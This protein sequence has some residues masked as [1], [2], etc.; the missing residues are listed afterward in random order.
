MSQR[1]VGQF[2]DDLAQEYHDKLAGM[3]AYHAVTARMI[4]AGVSNRVLSIGGLWNRATPEEFDST[5]LVGDLSVAMLR[6]LPDGTAGVLSDARG[7]PFASGAFDHLVFPLVLHHIT[8]NRAHT[9]RDNV[10]RALAEAR[11]LLDGGGT[12][13]ISEFCV[14]AMVY[15]AEL[16]LAPL[17]AAVLSLVDTPLVIMHSAAFLAES[18]ERAGFAEIEIVPVEA[19]DAGPFDLLRP[20]IGLPHLRLPRFLYPVT[21]TL[22]IARAI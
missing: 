8:E 2:F 9:A 18:M 13:W 4:E 11:R 15:G 3:Q 17:T 19:P 5:V 1:D 7:L 14:N 6:E 16:A 20:V 22:L 12:V 10:R 21:P